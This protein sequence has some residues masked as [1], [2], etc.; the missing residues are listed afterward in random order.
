MFEITY[1]IP[2]PE[3]P[4]GPAL[5]QFERLLPG[6]SMFVPSTLAMLTTTAD[7]VR[8]AVKKYRRAHAPDTKWR[9]AVKSNGIRV[10]RVE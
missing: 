7:R 4:K 2:P 3:A 1:D 10:W 6:G 8:W 5:Y 9:T